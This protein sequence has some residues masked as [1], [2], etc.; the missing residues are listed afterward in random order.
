MRPRTTLVLTAAAA[1]LALGGG[2]A[3]ADAAPAVFAQTDALTGN[4]IVAYDRAGDGTLT[5]AGV[6]PTG[7]LGGQLEGSV[8]DHLASQGSLA[9]DQADGLLLAVNAG[10]ETVSVFGV[11][12]DRL[13]LRQTI[14]SGGPLPVAIAVRDGLVYVLDAG[15]GG[16]VE[17]FRVIGGRLL[18][19][20]GSARA[21][22]LNPAAEPQFVNTPGQAGFTPDGSKL[23][24]TTK[25]NGNAVDVFAVRPTGLLAKTPVTDVL[26]G[27]VPF[28]FT[29]DH[30]G[31]LLLTE[32]GTNALASFTL[33]E[34]GGL[35]QLDVLG[36]EQKATC[37]VVRVGEKLYVSNTG[38]ATLTGFRSE[39]GGQLLTRLGNTSTDGGPVDSAVPPSGRYLYLQTGGE[40][41]LDEFAIE[42][43]GGLSKIGAV[44]IP[45]GVGGEGIVA[46]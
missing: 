28:A 5:Q 8:T 22:G 45:G 12:G 15:A 1:C 37:W 41:I 26:P 9:Y 25:A 19:L 10:S 14:A 18:P 16:S 42:P 27:A 36:T 6:Y 7:G 3:A 38:S 35:A 11:F 20:P 32:A 39:R 31:D 34:D 33:R 44:T 4:Q 2:S 30:Q 17:G 21:L 13:A 46:P 29:F 23:L 43:G 24:V 40:G